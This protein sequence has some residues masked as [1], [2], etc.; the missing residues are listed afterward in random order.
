LGLGRMSVLML[1]GSYCKEGVFL[2]EAL[3]ASGRCLRI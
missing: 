2:S 1:V 3:L